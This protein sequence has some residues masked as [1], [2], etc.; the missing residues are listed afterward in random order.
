MTETTA[1][2]G[3]AFQNLSDL[4][5]PSKEASIDFPGYDGFKINVTYL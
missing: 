2:S 4:L 3:A 5:T 1:P